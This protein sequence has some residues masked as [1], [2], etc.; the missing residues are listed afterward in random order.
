MHFGAEWA[1]RRNLDDDVGPKPPLP[2]APAP[3]AYV[4]Q[5][6]PPAPPAVAGCGSYP[7]PAKRQR[8]S[9]GELDTITILGIREKDLSP[10][11]LQQWFSERPGFV[12]MQVNERINGVFAKFSSHS[13]AMQVLDEANTMQFGAEWARRNLDL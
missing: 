12:A 6:M 13:Y 1:T 10:D 4:P 11:M 3:V 7:G 9:A 5:P 2:P 8:S